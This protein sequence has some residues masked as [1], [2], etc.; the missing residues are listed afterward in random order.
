MSLKKIIRCKDCVNRVYDFGVGFTAQ[1][2]LMCG[3]SGRLVD[4]DDGCTFGTRG[5]GG[6]YVVR[7]YEVDLKGYEAVN[8][9]WWLDEF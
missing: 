7:K 1:T 3:D 6:G 2:V 8:G 4:E 5:E 9:E